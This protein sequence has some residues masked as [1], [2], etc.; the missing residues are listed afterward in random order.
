MKNFEFFVYKVMTYIESG[1]ILVLGRWQTAA[2][3]FS[4]F[5]SPDG[6]KNGDESV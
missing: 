3:R 1:A 6:S 2:T 4:H 5:S